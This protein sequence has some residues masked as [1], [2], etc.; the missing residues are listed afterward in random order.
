MKN[1]LCSLTSEYAVRQEKFWKWIDQKVSS[2]VA[3]LPELVA[4]REG[5]DYN[6]GREAQ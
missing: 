6:Y 2:L 5:L 3:S 1:L 4:L